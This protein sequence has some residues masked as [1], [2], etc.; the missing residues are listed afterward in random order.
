[1]RGRQWA[2]DDLVE[3]LDQVGFAAMRGMIE[4]YDAVYADAEEWWAAKWTHGARYP[5]E[6][7]TPA[8]LARFREE[9]SAQLARLEQPGGLHERWRIRCTI[10]TKAARETVSVGVNG[11]ET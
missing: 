3:I 2:S 5:L 11:E 10:A 7:M 9:V 4:E 6:R 1:M 8:I